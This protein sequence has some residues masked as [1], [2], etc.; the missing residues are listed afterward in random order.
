MQVPP[1]PDADAVA[2]LSAAVL[3]QAAE[4]RRRAPRHRRNRPSRRRDGRQTARFPNKPE[5]IDKAKAWL[6]EMIEAEKA[7]TKGSISG[8]GGAASGTDLLFHE[9]CAELG[10]PTTVVLPI[11]KDDYR[12]QSVADGGPDWVEKFNN[13]VNAK[14]PIVLSD[15]PDLPNWASRFQ[16]TGCFSV[17][18]SG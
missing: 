5:C 15:N 3:N 6:R 16:T 12:R 18:T 11:P 2:A 1:R 17:A 4:G 9:V 7:Q 8:M 14:P 13:V 10:I